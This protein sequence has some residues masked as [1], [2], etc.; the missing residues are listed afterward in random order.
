MA[1]LHPCT[2]FTAIGERFAVQASETPI[3]LLQ[4]RSSRRQRREVVTPI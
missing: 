1:E 2:S 3:E 4:Q